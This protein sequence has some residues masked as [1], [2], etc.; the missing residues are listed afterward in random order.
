MSVIIRL[1]R[2]G[3]KKVD[4]YRIAVADSRYPRDGRCLEIIGYFHPQEEP[5]VVN[6]KE[7]RALYWLEQGATPSLKVRSL[8]KEQGIL[9]KFRETAAAK[10]G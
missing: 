5:S 4:K 8:L 7:D 10:T 9:A 3:R 1:T 2:V 6:I